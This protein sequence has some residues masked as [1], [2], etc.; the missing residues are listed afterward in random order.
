M[1]FPKFYAKKKKK[2]FFNFKKSRYSE[3]LTLISL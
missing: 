3:N 2:R 1:V